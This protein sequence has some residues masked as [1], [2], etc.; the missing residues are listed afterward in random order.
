MY[1]LNK[2]K[3]LFISPSML[4]NE[5]LTDFDTELLVLCDFEQYR[6]DITFLN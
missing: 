1:E 4:K 5:P 6:N 2:L 3:L